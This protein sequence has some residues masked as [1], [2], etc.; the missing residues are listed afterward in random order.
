MCRRTNVFLTDG[1]IYLFIGYCHLIIS[2]RFSI[3]MKH[4]FISVFLRIIA[5]YDKILDC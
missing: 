5:K 4:S 3:Y 1:Y 2:L